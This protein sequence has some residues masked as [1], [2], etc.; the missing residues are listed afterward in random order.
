MKIHRMCKWGIVGVWIATM[1]L[2]TSCHKRLGPT[3]IHVVDSVR[4][5]P[6]LILGEDLELIYVL[7]NTGKEV[8]AITDVQPSCPTIETPKT[9][10][11]T[12]PPGEEVV[13]K[14]IFHSDKNMGYTQHSIRLFGNIAPKGVAELVFDTHIVR[15]SVDLSDY[16][17]YYQENVKSSGE[18]II[19]A[20][21]G[22]QGYN[23][24]GG[25]YATPDNPADEE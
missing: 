19:D 3:T 5:Y 22:K 24:D 6:P 13:L 9:N 12:V 2:F 7:R 20:A 23:V 18:K 8:L 11:T 4:H 1:A 14:F 16:E 15:P 25:A 10:I 21:Y 17:E